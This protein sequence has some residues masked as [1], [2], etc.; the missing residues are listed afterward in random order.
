M[1]NVL[2]NFISSTR[3]KN[4]YVN[5]N[6]IHFNPLRE[7]VQITLHAYK[8]RFYSIHVHTKLINLIKNN[9]QNLKY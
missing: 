1:Y 3:K 4:V 7:N 5:K 8:I 2:D 6:R 9:K